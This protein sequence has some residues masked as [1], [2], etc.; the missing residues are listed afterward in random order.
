MSETQPAADLDDQARRLDPERWLSSRFIADPAARA[1]AMAV[2]AFD[3][4]L[5]RAPKVA[6]NA[7]MGEIRLTWWREVLDEVFEGRP[8]RQ[9]PTAQALAA[10]IGR[11]G[12]PRGPLEAMID[13]R[14]RELDPAPMNL[15]DALEWARGSARRS[16]SA[17]AP[18]ASRVSPPRA[19]IRR[20]FT[21]ATRPETVSGSIRSTAATRLRKDSTPAVRFDRQGESARRR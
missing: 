15:A 17:R 21:A 10:A 8:I 12:L 16:I 3:Y 9:H 2:Y 7:L 19:S 6:S 18:T 11:H 4:E 1:D 14:Y 5:A 20:P 13:A